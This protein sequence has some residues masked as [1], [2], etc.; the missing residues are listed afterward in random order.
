MPHSV[1]PEGSSNGDI[2][3][4]DSLASDDP[5][6]ENESDEN[7]VKNV[8]PSDTAGLQKDISAVK[9]NDLDLFSTDDEDDEF[10]SSAPATKG[11]VEPITSSPPAM[12]SYVAC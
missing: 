10:G 1:T 3:L 2:D 12:T 9:L 6:S 11:N 5:A 8:I 4:P 7:T